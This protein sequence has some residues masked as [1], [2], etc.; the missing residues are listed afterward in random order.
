[1]H[2]KWNG[3]MLRYKYYHLMKSDSVQDV[4]EVNVDVNLFRATTAES[5]EKEPHKLVIICL[6]LANIIIYG[7]VIPN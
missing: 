3:I 2:L 4:E 7:K 1:M 5:R 6:C